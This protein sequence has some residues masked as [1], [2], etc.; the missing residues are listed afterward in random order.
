MI[1]SHIKNTLLTVTQRVYRYTAPATPVFPYIIW[2]DEM[3]SDM[4]CGDG[5]KLFKTIE[6]SIDLYTKTADDSF[7]DKIEK[8]LNDA[9]ICF[10]LN[11][12]QLEPTTRIIHHE[13]V[14]NIETEVQ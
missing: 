14:W 8:A 12:V 7:I 2:Q 6:G 13:W 4:F 3:E 1:L 10:R 9:G 5:R 11:S